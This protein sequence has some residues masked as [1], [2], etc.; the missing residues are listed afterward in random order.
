ME[1]A[2][3]S[4]QNTTISPQH[5]KMSSRRYDHTRFHPCAPIHPREVSDSPFSRPPKHGYDTP[6]L[7][8]KAEESLSLAKFTKVPPRYEEYNS[9]LY[10][11]E[12]VSTC[13]L[14]EFAFQCPLK[15]IS[16]QDGDPRGLYHKLTKEIS[17]GI[18]CA[19]FESN[20]N[21]PHH[22]FWHIDKS[23]GCDEDGYVKVYEF[24]SLIF[25]VYHPTG[26]RMAGF[27]CE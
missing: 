2:R 21:W 10:Y 1:L 19:H 13:I 27:E 22:G 23:L 11:T 5:R 26:Y 20:P 15:P 3:K 16:S 4:A 6:H 18:P 7:E 25:E 17:E 12:K 8:S 24:G 14:N 9:K